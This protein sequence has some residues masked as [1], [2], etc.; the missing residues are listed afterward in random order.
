MGFMKDLLQDELGRMR[1]MVQTDEGAK[2]IIEMAIEKCREKPEKF[3]GIEKE[4]LEIFMMALQ[5][6]AA[7]LG[8]DR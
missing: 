7:K 6:A 8:T 1:R 4:F 2:K 5:R 3:R